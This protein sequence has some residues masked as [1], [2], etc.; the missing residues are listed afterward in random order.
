VAAIAAVSPWVVT[1][2]NI[3]EQFLC[4]AELARVGAAVCHSPVPSTLLHA[5]MLASVSNPE[6]IQC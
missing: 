4:P 1:E 6:L 3:I 2:N 5:W